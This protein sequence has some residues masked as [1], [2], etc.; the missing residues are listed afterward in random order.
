MINKL[1]DEI[2]ELIYKFYYSK[3]VLTELKPKCFYKYSLGL[4]RPKFR[5]N[6]NT[7]DSAYCMACWRLF[8]HL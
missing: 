2:I 4:G 6:L 7:I 3:Y 5:C 8:N 1:P